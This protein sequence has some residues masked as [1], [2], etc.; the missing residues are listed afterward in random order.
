[1]GAIKINGSTSGST[2]ITAPA[3]GS[4]ETIELFTALA[5]K[6]PLASP[7]FT[8]TPA[9]PSTT[10]LD[11]STLN[12]PGLVLITSES[13]SAVSSVS[14]NNCFSGSYKNYRLLISGTSSGTG[15]DLR[16]RWRVGG[17][18]NSTASSYVRQQLIA[19]STTV[20]A[21]RQTLDYGAFGQWSSTLISTSSVDVF[22]VFAADQTGWLAHTLSSENDAGM[23]NYFGNHNQTTS[24]DGITLYPSSGTFTGTLRV[25]GYKD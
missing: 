21:S 20:A 2:T 12:L 9:L 17:S 23:Y 7:T 11:G 6:A 14:V 15:V 18:D 16:F 1:M 25:Y 8:G 24:Y 5:A 22:D 10:T 4:D 19:A 13:F 3:T